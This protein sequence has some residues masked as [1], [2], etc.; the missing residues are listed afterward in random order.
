MTP[1]SPAFRVLILINVRWW[2]ATAFYAVNIA[3]ILKK[4]GHLVWVG[5]NRTYPAYRI[6]RAFG[7]KVVPLQFY[8]MNPFSL[9]PS[10]F[11]M[12]GLIKNEK[13]DIINSHRSEDHS[14]ALLAK[15][16]TGVKTVITRG[17]Q[18]PI[19]ANF[20]SAFRYRV[21]DAAILTCRNIVE[22]NKP[23]FSSPGHKN[24][25]IYGCVDENHFSL[26]RS[27]AQTV[28]KYGLDAQK[29]RIGLVGRFSA[30]KDQ[31]TLIKAASII[32][33]KH[34]NVQFVLAG[35][36]ID[37]TTN[38]LHDRIQE[39]GLASHFKLFPVVEDV[40]DLMNALDIGIITSIE[41]ETISRV[42]LEFMFLG[43]PVIGTSVN[44]IGEIIRPGECGELI[45]PGD[46]A[47]L[48][49]KIIDLVESPDRIA[50]YGRKA[51]QLYN[52][53]Y[54]EPVFYQQYMAVFDSVVPNDDG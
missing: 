41:S 5:C 16:I 30:V 38:D 2:N 4:N 6:A 18:R 31:F 21:C 14:F 35:K 43:K 7:L 52:Q 13:I 26:S 11:R 39:L 27:T 44:A 33:E 49:A 50:A 10:F 48:A 12:L 8:G 22:Q 23:I 34:E 32:L 25:V 1:A 20:W 17:D 29:I 45:A 51:K 46:A 42:L 28:V 47:E 36:E 9:G 24:R 3:R 15:M 37:I 40:A 19:S 54:S 53:L